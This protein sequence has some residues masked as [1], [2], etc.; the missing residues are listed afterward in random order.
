[1]RIG[2][3]IN[4]IILAL[5]G[6][7][8]LFCVLLSW[9][10]WS[11]GQE[12][13]NLM[14]QSLAPGMVLSQVREDAGQA[15]FWG[16]EYSILGQQHQ[17][18]QARLHFSA[19]DSLQQGFPARKQWLA[20]LE[21]T[22]EAMQAHQELAEL[23]ATRSDQFRETA[24]RF[25]A[26]ETRWQAHENTLPD[27]TIETRQKRNDRINTI[28]EVI[29][30]VNEYLAASPQSD[31][32]RIPSMQPPLKILAALPEIPDEEK[33]A[34]V[35]DA[36]GELD[37]ISIRWP[38]SSRYLQKSNQ[39]LASAGSAWLEETRTQMNQNKIEVQK[40]GEAWVQKSRLAALWILMGAALV[41]VFSAVAIVSAK[42]IFGTPLKNVAKGMD[43]DLKALEPVSQRLAQ[44][45][46]SAGSSGTLLNDE[47]KGLSRLMGELNESLVLHDEAASSSAQAMAGIGEDAAAASLNLGQLNQNMAGLQETSDKTE[48]IVRSI[49]E[50]ATQT[51]LLALNA[52]VEAAHAG[53]AGA[54]FAVVADEV[55]DLANRCAEAA[56]ETSQLIEESRA[57]T[58]AGVESATKA[59][60]ILTRID[61][62]SA[63]AGS[64]TQ[65]LAAAA[66]SHSRQSRQLCQNVDQTW[67]IAFKTL[68]DAK[69]AMAST[70]PLLTHLADLKQLSQ[71]LAGLEFRTPSG[72]RLRKKPKSDRKPQ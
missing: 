61:E 47:L 52:A 67:K 30:M 1:M 66:G 11:R 51:N 23:Q 56:R 3:G 58:T 10:I 9:Q 16:R 48:A 49:N 2:S 69:T 41:L 64:Q 33:L 53:E 59:A 65:A 36:L 46:N 68:N 24:R 34:G 18:E 60:E 57:R 28:S 55:R 50:I 44:A 4:V 5:G 19:T 17:L 42:R 13:G 6:V 20:A 27:I 31:D 40:K 29:L 22:A 35:Q 71:K 39:R 32:H 7:C 8:S 38:E 62:V 25:M 14:D 54:G 37:I 12:T 63:Q 70:M 72:F 26:A 15:I 21:V 45:S 43:R